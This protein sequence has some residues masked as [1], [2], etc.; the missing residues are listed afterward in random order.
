MQWLPVL[1]KEIRS[2]LVGDAGDQQ[3]K[4]T[5][6]RLVRDLW[7]FVQCE[8]G[9]KLLSL[10]DINGWLRGP[11]VDGRAAGARARPIED[12]SNFNSLNYIVIIWV[13]VRHVQGPP[14]QTKV[15]GRI[16]QYDKRTIIY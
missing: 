14:C 13:R 6:E 10:S 15:T 16:N 12:D 7:Q 2:V 11:T 4:N 8:G 1:P 9:K 3:F 5:L